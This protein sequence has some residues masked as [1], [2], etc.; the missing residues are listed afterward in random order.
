[1]CKRRRRFNRS[2]QYDSDPVELQWLENIATELC[3]ITGGLILTVLFGVL[4]LP[5]YAYRGLCKQ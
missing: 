3:I 5:V 2:S 1:M 4:M